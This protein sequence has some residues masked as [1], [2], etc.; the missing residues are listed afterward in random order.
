MEV[1]D[2]AVEVDVVSEVPIRYSYLDNSSFHDSSP[3]KDYR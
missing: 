3:N 2:K 1:D